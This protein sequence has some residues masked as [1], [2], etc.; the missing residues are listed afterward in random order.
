M[1][2]PANGKI[3]HILFAATNT[4][5]ELHRGLAHPGDETERSDYLKKAYGYVD[6]VDVPLGFCQG[7]PYDMFGIIPMERRFFG[8][9]MAAWQE[10]YPLALMWASHRPYIT[11]SDH[12]DDLLVGLFTGAGFPCRWPLGDRDHVLL[13]P[14]HRWD[15]WLCRWFNR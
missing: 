14:A 2:T 3:S 15:F 9:D 7:E 1:P 12:M 10:R 13:G 11:G 8:V 4:R 6:G 5:L